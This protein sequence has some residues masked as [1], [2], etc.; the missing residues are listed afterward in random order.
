MVNSTL[1][2]SC[3]LNEMA[4]GG[5]T[6]ALRLCLERILPPRRERPAHFALP[7]LRSPADAAAAIAAIAAAVADGDL[8]A[9]R[10]WRAG[11]TR[12]HICEDTTS[13]RF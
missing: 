8:T 1:K 9:Q 12:R 10:S 3:K 4:L 6:V 5:D 2:G 11:E 7:E 13:E